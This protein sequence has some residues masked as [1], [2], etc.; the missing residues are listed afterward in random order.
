M[1]QTSSSRAVTPPLP[2]GTSHWSTPTRTAVIKASEFVDTLSPT[3]RRRKN[4]TKKQLYKKLDVPERT[5]RRIVRSREPHRSNTTNLKPETRGG[6]SILTENDLRYLELTLQRFPF[7]AR[8]LSYAGLAKYCNL[9]V[10]AMTIRRAM[11]QLDF[12]RCK[13][14]QRRWISE[15]AARLRVKFAKTMLKKYPKPSDWYNVRFSDETHFGFGSHG[16]WWITRRPGEENCAF[17]VQKTNEPKQKDVKRLHAWAAV[18]YNFKSDLIFYDN[19]TSNGK[20]DQKTY[21]S[22][23]AQA[24]VGWPAGIVL[25]EDRD[26]GHGTHLNIN[27]QKWKDESTF[28]FYFNCAASPDLSPIENAWLS[29]KEYLRKSEHWDDKTVEEL[30]RQGWKE[31]SQKTINSWVDSMPARLQQVIDSKGQMT[32]W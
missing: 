19:G 27:L 4:I 6:K 11:H 13:S 18:G 22:I 10:S 21:E 23:L 8:K 7:E 16:R 15:K 28:K 3:T 9:D 12:R 24:T 32:T 2:I 17:C 26:S 1:P 14:C 5:A 29:P 30:A 25:E 20:M 31:L